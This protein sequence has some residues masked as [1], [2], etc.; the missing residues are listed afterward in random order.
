MRG[1]AQERDATA[2]PPRAADARSYNRVWTTPVGSV[3]A[4]DAR[5][6]GVVFRK[7]ASRCA[8][9]SSG[10]RNARADSPKRVV[11]NMSC[12]PSDELSDESSDEFAPSR[13]RF[14]RPTSRREMPLPSHREKRSSLKA[15]APFAPGGGLGDNA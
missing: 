13:S 6:N 11:P 7:S 1:V 5:S 4:M 14:P 15:P 2:T 12:P 9:R 10:V 8:R 3:V